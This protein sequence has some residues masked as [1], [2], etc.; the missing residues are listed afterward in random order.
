LPYRIDFENEATATAPAQRVVVTDQ[1]DHNFDWK[2]FTLTG[3]GFGDTDFAIPPGSQHY[4]TTIDITENGQPIEVDIELG[5]NPQTGLITATFQTIDPRTQLPPDVL[6][7]FLPPE[8]GTGRGKG[9]FTYVVQPKASLPTGT[10]IRNVATVTFDANAPI[11]TDQVD[12]HDPSKGRDPAKQDLITIDAGPPTSHVAP[13]PATEN[14]ADFTVTW[15]GQDDPGGSGIGSYDVY[16]SDNGGPFT[17][18][19]SETTQTS[20]T[21]HGINQHTYAFYSVAT[22]NVGHVEATPT[23]SQATTLIHVTVGDV[24]ILVA[25]SAPVSQYGQA[26]TFTATINPLTTGLSAPAGTVQFQI[27]GAPLDVPVHLVGGQAV[28]PVIAALAVGGHTITAL[29]ADDPNYHSTSGSASQ[30]VDK[31]DLTVTANAQSMIS[32][33]A[34]P[35]L[36]YTITGFVNGDGPSSLSAPVVVTTTATAGS[37]PGVYPIIVSGATSPNYAI[38]FVDG[39]LTVIATPQVT[40]TNVQEVFNKKHQVIQITIGFSGP[41]NAG[42]ADSLATY[43]LTIAG[44]HGSF[45]AKNARTIA[46]AAAVYRASTHSVTLAP[47]KPFGLTKPVQLRVHGLL[48]GGDAVAIL[49]KPGVRIE[50]RRQPGTLPRLSVPAV[51]HLMSTGSRERLLHS[52]VTAALG[53]WGSATAAVDSGRDDP[54]AGPWVAIVDSAALEAEGAPWYERRNRPGIRAPFHRS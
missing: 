14:S 6:T 2:T 19:Q 28:S 36:T 35:T 10:A 3:V 53:A 46:L 8:D 39:T 9:Y 26:L 37:P 48:P 34:V 23:A 7:G 5:L 25:S 51:D 33:G 27:D 54:A 42:L 50:A 1:L 30:T 38:T 29:Y 21:F 44:K 52:L 40:M 49:S 24:N 43:R 31:A 45:T 18:W 12:P 15:S 20:A 32:G 22:D 13:L 4:Q 11:T 41:V 47:R 16:V 17:I